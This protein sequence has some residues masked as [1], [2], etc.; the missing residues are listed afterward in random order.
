MVGVSSVSRSPACGRSQQSPKTRN[1]RSR[2]LTSIQSNEHSAGAIALE[3]LYR[4]PCN[5][6]PESFCVQQTL[7][8]SAALCSVS[9]IYHAAHVASLGCV[10]Q[11]AVC[12][13]PPFTLCNTPHS[14]KP[15]ARSQQL[16]PAFTKPHKCIHAA[17]IHATHC[18]SHIR[19]MLMISSGLFE[20]HA[21]LNSSDQHRNSSQQDVNTTY[22]EQQAS[23]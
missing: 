13:F 5:I 6:L 16:G 20:M 12:S 17:L 15:V 23:D 18:R 1:S 3:F 10:C 19:S 14:S 9:R 8:Q 7:L 2:P 11:P 21:L 22:H 4:Y